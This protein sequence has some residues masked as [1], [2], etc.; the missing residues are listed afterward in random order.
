MRLYQTWKEARVRSL[1]RSAWHW[2]DKQ[3]STRRR[4][5]TAPTTRRTA[6][7]GSSSGQRRAEAAPSHCA[8]TADRVRFSLAP[9][10][11]VLHCTL[12]GIIYF[13]MIDGSTMIC[14]NSM[15]TRPGGS[16]WL[17]W[18]RRR[19]NDG[20]AGLWL[21]NKSCSFLSSSKFSDAAPCLELSIL[22]HMNRDDIY[23]PVVSCHL[24]NPLWFHRPQKHQVWLDINS[25]D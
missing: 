7:V 25:E 15:L 13:G 1:G 10:R 17:P 20:Q 24:N 23:L 19:G 14:T 2:R 16:G 6:W 9:F 12:H 11:P 5:G 4:T 3:L 21:R 8:A 22:H 18:W